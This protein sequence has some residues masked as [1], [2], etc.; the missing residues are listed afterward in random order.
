[1]L[2]PEKQTIE[3]TGARGKPL[4]GLTNKTIRQQTNREHTGDNGEDM[5]HLEGVETSTK[6]G[7]TNQGVT[8]K[9]LINQYIN[10]YINCT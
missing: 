5:Q 4:V 8:K 6:T 2:K 10:Q 3:K 7:E 9:S 1:L